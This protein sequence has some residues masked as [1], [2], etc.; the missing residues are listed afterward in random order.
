MKPQRKQK[1]DTMIPVGPDG[2]SI[3]VANLPT[4]HLQ[5][6]IVSML[7]VT[8]IGVSVM[9]TREQAVE[10]QKALRSALA[11]EDNELLS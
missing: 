9:L 5:V 3:A 6:G 2:D 7:S 11:V 10:F 1:I 8:T 4:G